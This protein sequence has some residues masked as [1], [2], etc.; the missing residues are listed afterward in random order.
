MAHGAS[1]SITVNKCFARDRATYR[2]TCSLASPLTGV[3]MVTM[4][5]ASNP[6]NRCHEATS[7]PFPSPHSS[8]LRVAGIAPN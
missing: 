8:K 1:T 5:S 7:T 2:F 6:L 3:S 4:A